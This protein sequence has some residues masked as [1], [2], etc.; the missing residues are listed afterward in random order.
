MA[1]LR[2][3]WEKEEKGVGHSDADGY[4][5]LC[6]VIAVHPQVALGGTY[7]GSKPMKALKR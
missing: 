3:S 4:K 7:R 5:C 1:H 2:L 6:Q